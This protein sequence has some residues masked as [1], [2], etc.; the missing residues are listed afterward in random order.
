MARKWLR[1]GALASVFAIVA[2]GN[3]G[4]SPGSLV[5]AAYAREAA[6][7]NGAAQTDT[8]PASRLPREA[9]TTLSLIAAGGPYPYEKDGAVFGNFERIL[10]KMR[11]G[12]YHEYTV[13]TPRARNR[14]A[15]RIVCGGALRRVDNCYYTD[16]HYNSFKRIVD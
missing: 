3:I 15:R 2:M 9:V 13:P 10:P 16:D 12:Y 4:V 6:A 1:N 5:S 14:G 7:V 8:V 11:R